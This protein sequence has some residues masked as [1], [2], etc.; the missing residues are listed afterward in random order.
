MIVDWKWSGASVLGSNVGWWPDNCT[1]KCRPG[2][3][4]DFFSFLWFQCNWKI[5]SSS[6][7]V[8][9]AKLQLSSNSEISTSKETVSNTRRTFVTF[10][11]VALAR[12]MMIA[13][14]LYC[15]RLGVGLSS[16]SG[17]HRDPRVTLVQRGYL[18]GPLIV[19]LLHCLSAITPF[20][21]PKTF[22][23]RRSKLFLGHFCQQAD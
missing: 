5:R 8:S 11:W 22:P 2:S 21:W 9:T 16:S 17:G 12:P 15:V 1:M 18:I 20:F 19:C 3:N 14:H 6:D 4:G 13:C 7:I 23:G 10:Q